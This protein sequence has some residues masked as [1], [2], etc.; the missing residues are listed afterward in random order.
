MQYR[1]V[2]SSARTALRPVCGGGYTE[3]NAYP[4]SQVRGTAMGTE[5]EVLRR[6]RARPAAASGSAR[7]HK[8]DVA[9]RSFF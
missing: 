2:R 1:R 5:T 6:W 8:P 4:T 7:G 9:Q 3:L